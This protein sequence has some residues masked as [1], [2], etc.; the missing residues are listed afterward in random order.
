M[1]HWDEIDG[2]SGKLLKKIL[3]GEGRDSQEDSGR[4][5][6]KYKDW[7][8]LAKQSKKVL[9]YDANKAFRELQHRK[10]RRRHL[11]TR[12][13]VA[14]SIMLL[15]SLSIF[16]IQESP[17]VKPV[18]KIEPGYKKATLTLSDGTSWDIR[19]TAKVFQ[20][21]DSEFKVDSCGLSIFNNAIAPSQTETQYHTLSVPRGGEYNLTLS[22]GTQVW[23]N[24]ESELRFPTR[25]NANNRTVYC[26]GEVYFDVTRNPDSPFIVRLDKGEV[27][28]LGT[29]F[30]TSDYEN[31]VVEVTLVTGAVRFKAENGDSVSLTPSQRLVYNTATDSISVTTVD[32]RAYTAWKDNLFCFE[33]ETLEDIMQTLSRWYNIDIHFESE[34][35]KGRHFSGIIEK[36]TEIKSFLELF[37][38]GTGIKFDIYGHEITVRKSR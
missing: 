34:D 14:A 5:T 8:T 31:S 36:Y 11:M 33:D 32:T 4:L 38:T 3:L 19:E 20:V 25:F 9:K 29:E 1:A 18:K 16:L 26:K 13:S 15:F 22:D 23:L 2:I 7:D 21:K 28:V 6:D 10:Y 30:C 17:E 35:L 37:E 24:S 12:W 27:T